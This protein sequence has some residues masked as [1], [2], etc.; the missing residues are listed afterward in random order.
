M[1]ENY[2][3]QQKA[4]KMSKEY[5]IFANGSSWLRAD[6]HLHTKSD[7]EFIF[8]ESENSFVAEYIDKLIEQNIRVGVIT[9]HNKFDYNEYKALSQKARKNEIYLLPGIELSVND[10]K[11]GIH[12]LIVF[13]DEEWLSN[14]NDYINQFLSSTFAG[15]HNFENENGRSNDSLIETIKKLDSFN[16]D[17]F[18]LLAHIEQRS[19]FYEELDGGR[20]IEFANNPL[21]RISKSKNKRL[22]RKFKKLV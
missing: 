10:G 12:T 3:F 17:Y 22:C 5:K 21:F 9:N 19:G 15:K 18:I 2:W 11:N 16:K 8:N 20:I 7:K 4:K 1:L 14:G 13:N 6:F